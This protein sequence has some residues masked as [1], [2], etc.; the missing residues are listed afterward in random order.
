[1]KFPIFFNPSCCFSQIYP[2]KCIFEEGWGTAVTQEQRS[3]A[4]MKKLFKPSALFHKQCFLMQPEPVRA[5][6]ISYVIPGSSNCS[7]DL[8][9][10]FQLVTSVFCL[11]VYFIFRIKGSSD[12]HSTL[13]LLLFA[14][15]TRLTPERLLN[16]SSEAGALSMAP[17]I[18]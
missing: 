18:D 1:M 16:H 3:S 5:Q 11:E 6:V 14:Q 12:N 13:E 2:S 17:H 9:T 15:I 4:R 7:F 10:Q 8:N